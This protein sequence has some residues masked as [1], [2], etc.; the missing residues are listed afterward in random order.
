VLPETLQRAVR[1]QGGGHYNHSLFWQMLKKN[2]GRPSAA[3]TA[4]I[5]KTFGSIDQFW[6]KFSE[7]AAKHFGSGWVWLVVN[8]TKKLEIVTTKNQNSP[9][10]EKQT[11]ILGIDLWEHAY[12]LKYR[13]V[14]ADYVAAFPKIVNWE[15]VSGRYAKAVA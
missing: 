11:E 2:G 6:T 15:F 12:Y 14:R 13:N 3:L 5:D 4:E 8:E 9:I 1:N 10:S 7:T